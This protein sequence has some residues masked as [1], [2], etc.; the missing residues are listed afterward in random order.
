MFW[1]NYVRYCR[2]IG[3]PPNTV[4]SKCGITSSGTVT[5]WKNGAVPRSKIVNSLVEYFN[6]KGVECSVHDLFADAEEG[7]DAVS[8]REKLR[9]SPELKILFDAAEDAPSSALLEAAALI[10]RYK[11]QSK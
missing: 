6:S 10:M 2:M 9:S 5:G 7:A 4:A 3:E 8:V 11:E 1:T